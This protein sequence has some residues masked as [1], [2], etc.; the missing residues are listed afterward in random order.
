MV[1][2]W[3][4]SALTEFADN[5]VEIKPE[6]DLFAAIVDVNAIRYKRYTKDM[7][8]Q[9]FYNGEFDEYTYWMHYYSFKSISPFYNKILITDK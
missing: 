5:V 9:P 6:G 1:L 3:D 4:V 2:P 7:L 8:K